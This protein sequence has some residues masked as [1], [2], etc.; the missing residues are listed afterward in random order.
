LVNCQKR[1]AKSAATQQ[2]SCTVAVFEEQLEA[3][4]LAKFI[5]IR[6]E[7]IAAVGIEAV[8]HTWEKFR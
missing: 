6:I 7:A 4:T 8:D 5:T 2:F 1:S 3:T